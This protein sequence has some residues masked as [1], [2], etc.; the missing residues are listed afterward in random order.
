MEPTIVFF[1]DYVIKEGNF[2]FS[3]SWEPMAH[4]YQELSGDEKFFDLLAEHLDDPN[5]SDCLRVFYMLMGLGFDGCYKQ[6]KEYVERRMKLCA[7][8]CDVGDQLTPEALCQKAKNR[9][10][11]KRYQLHYHSKHALVCVF[12]C[13]LLLLFA[14]SWNFYK[15]K[16]YTQ[17]FYQTL[18]ETSQKLSFQILRNGNVPSQKQGEK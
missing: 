13:L 16:Q 2:P 6:D 4:A 7:L 11:Q 1:I 9:S 14:G 10:S 17:S 15:Y 12:S 18:K 8:R 5:A 3:R